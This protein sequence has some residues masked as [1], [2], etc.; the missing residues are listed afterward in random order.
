MN[1]CA[2]I[3]AARQESIDTILELADCPRAGSRLVVTGCLAERYGPNCA[4][5]CPRST[6]WPAS[7]CRSP[8]AATRGTPP[9]AHRALLLR[10]AQPAPARGHGAVGL[11]KGGRGVR[12]AVR[13][14]RHP[15]VPG[16]AAV[17]SRRRRCST[18][19]TPSAT[20][21]ARWSSWPRTWPR[22][23]STAAPRTG[24]R[25]PGRDAAPIVEL[26]RAVAERVERVRLLYLYPSALDDE[27]IDAIVAHRRALLRPVAPARVASAGRA[28][29]AVGRRGPLPRADRPRSGRPPPTPR[30]GR[31]SSWAI[32]GR[33]RRTTTRSSRSWPRPGSTGPGSSPSPR[34]RGPTPPG[35]PD[36]VPAELALERLRECSEVQD[37]ITAERRAALV[38][39]RSGARRRPGVGRSHREAP[40]IDGIVHV[41]RPRSASADVP[42]GGR[43][44]PAAAGRP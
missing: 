32:R 20:G 33:P 14:L 15:V 39:E 26:I 7:G 17:A 2:F 18:R 41:R 9:S 38:G 37:R 36:A 11:C 44:D 4:T 10:P 21:C 22:G 31:R 6:W 24:S 8:W 1:T 40:E 19:S 3:E 27:L 16:P 5:P 42:P 43:S 13:L 25:G 29:E 30:C 12:P 23:A 35:L 34:S 28:D